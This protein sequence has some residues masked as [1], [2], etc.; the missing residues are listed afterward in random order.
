[1]G[2]ELD[3]ELE[4]DKE[5]LKLKREAHKRHQEARDALAGLRRTSL[6]REDALVL[7]QE[8]EKQTSESEVDALGDKYEL[9]RLM[10]KLTGLKRERAEALAEA[11]QKETAANEAAEELRKH[12]AIAN[13]A[14]RDA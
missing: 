12:R 9:A 14:G 1:M 10:S 2:A 11:T 4:D 7:L 13:M 3:K 5:L 8:Q 6:L